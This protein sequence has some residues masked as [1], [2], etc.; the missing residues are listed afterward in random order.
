[1]RARASHL[2]CLMPALTALDLL[3]LKAGS[4]AGEAFCRLDRIGRGH[5]MILCQAY[6]EALPF[7]LYVVAILPCCS[8]SSCEAA[9]RGLE[10]SASQPSVLSLPAR[11]MWL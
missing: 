6:F 2:G 4:W 3:V 8:F 5:Y 1:M 7:D 10:Q 11:A 9:F